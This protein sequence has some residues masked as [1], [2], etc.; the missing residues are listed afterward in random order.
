MRSI[1]YQRRAESLNN[2]SISRVLTQLKRRELYLIRCAQLCGL[3]WEDIDFQENTILFR[4]QHSKTG[5]KWHIPLH[6]DL[7]G[8]LQ[9]PEETDARGLAGPIWPE[10]PKD[11][12]RSGAAGP[13]L[14]GPDWQARRFYIEDNARVGEDWTQ[15]KERLTAELPGRPRALLYRLARIIVASYLNSDFI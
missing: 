13:Y 5:D 6:E 3:T 1:A 4:E 7:H 12:R 8:T 15:A 14:E 9:V 2:V 11:G 10:G